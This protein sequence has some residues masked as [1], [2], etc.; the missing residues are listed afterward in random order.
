MESIGNMEII[1]DSNG[2]GVQPMGTKCTTLC[3]LPAV[4]C[5]AIA[6]GLAVLGIVITSSLAPAVAT[7]GGGVGSVAGDETAAGQ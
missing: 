1:N 7:L 4:A 2:L 5:A 3:L 6:C